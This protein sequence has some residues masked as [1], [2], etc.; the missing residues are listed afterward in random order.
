MPLIFVEIRSILADLAPT[1][2]GFGVPIHDFASICDVMG[3]SASENC[4]SSVL[5]DF[6]T[7]P[8]ATRI[9]AH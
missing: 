1:C 9:Y 5:G 6:T 2:P 8:L 7:A 3:V 4:E